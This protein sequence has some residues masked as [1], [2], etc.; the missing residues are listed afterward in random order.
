MTMLLGAASGR[1]RSL[2]AG[3]IGSVITRGRLGS[4]VVVTLEVSRLADLLSNPATRR[5][6]FHAA[7]RRYCDGHRD[8]GGRYAARL[9]AKLALRSLAEEGQP[10]AW[11]KMR[12][13]HNQRGAPV[14]LVLRSRWQP[15]RRGRLS[16]SHHGDLALAVLAV[17]AGRGSSL[18]R[19]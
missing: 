19:A 9:A 1:V 7:E 10:I 16:L 11:Y 8:T 15:L 3:A 14:L 6:L 18:T 2:E 5:Q 12:V 4:L 17:G 13:T